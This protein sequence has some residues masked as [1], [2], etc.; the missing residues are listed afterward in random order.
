MKLTVYHKVWYKREIISFIYSVQEYSEWRGEEVD[1]QYHMELTKNINERGT[2]LDLNCKN[3]EYFLG[4]L[5]YY[6]CDGEKEYID[7]SET[8]LGKEIIKELSNLFTI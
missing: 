4:E 8:K 2:T 5:C 6:L 7:L 3:Y 1:K